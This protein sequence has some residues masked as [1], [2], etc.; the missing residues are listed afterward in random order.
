MH[1]FC[2]TGAQNS[3]FL[4]MT[5]KLKQFYAFYLYL[6]PSEPGGKRR[7]C[8]SEM[9]WRLRSCLNP[10]IQVLMWY[11]T[12]TCG[13]TVFPPLISNCHVE[14]KNWEQVCCLSHQISLPQ[15]GVCSRLG[16]VAEIKYSLITLLQRKKKQCRHTYHQRSCVG[17]SL[18]LLGVLHTGGDNDSTH[19]AAFLSS[20][21]RLT[22][23]VLLSFKENILVF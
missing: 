6:L 3:V 20:G 4:P 11:F 22:A 2:L 18:C 5:L 8:A 17:S 9:M 14:D 1:L 16:R 15:V 21:F 10:K 12:D 7:S 13:E 19:T 23:V